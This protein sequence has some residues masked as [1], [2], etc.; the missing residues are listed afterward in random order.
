MIS[1]AMIET[2]QGY[3]PAVNIY[4]QEP[5]A[6]HTTFRIGGPAECVIEM[7]NAVQ[8]AK[9]Q[10]YLRQ[11]EYPFTVVG[12]GSNLLVSDKGYQGIVL[13]IGKKMSEITVEGTR[14]RAQAGA[15][16]A[17]AAAAALKHGLTGL[18][19]ASGIPGTLGG[20][21]VMNAGAYGGELAQVVREVQVVNGEGEE[22]CLDNETMEFGY[23]RSILRKKPFTVT[24]VTME[25][26]PGDAAQ[27]KDKMD[28]LAAKRREKQPLQ[29]PSAGSTFKRPEGYYAGELIMKA[30]MRGFQIGGARVSD[31]HCGFVVNMGNATAADVR[32]VICEVQSRVKECFGVELEPEV[33]FL[34]DF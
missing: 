32:D 20:G 1:S 22:L 28:K 24:E 33:V 29:F 3:V 26:Q 17:Q 16:M 10:R 8:V 7:E 4:L 12:N 30:G 13:L 31:K 2:I 15:T 5:M 21:V 27:I 18:E 19:F 23:R 11:V 34:G 14:I 25:L 9:L 6:Q